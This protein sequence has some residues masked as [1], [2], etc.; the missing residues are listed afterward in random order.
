MSASKEGA[1]GTRRTSVEDGTVRN[2]K[3]KDGRVRVPPAEEV[4]MVVGASRSSR[5]RMA[6]N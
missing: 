4:G 1:W 2:S 3:K 6:N 5:I